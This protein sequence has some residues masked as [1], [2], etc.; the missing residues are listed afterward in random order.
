MPNQDRT[1]VVSVVDTMDEEPSRNNRFA[2]ETDGFEP[3]SIDCM[4]LE[5]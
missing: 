5:V 4:T 3:K 1:A 2:A